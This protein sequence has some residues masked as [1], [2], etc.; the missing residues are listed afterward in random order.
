MHKDVEVTLKDANQQKCHMNILVLRM[1]R[2]ELV[3][4][5]DKVIAK[6]D[7]LYFKCPLLVRL[8]YV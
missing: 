7:R 2:N 5:M 3:L 8:N 4:N 6:P 1:K